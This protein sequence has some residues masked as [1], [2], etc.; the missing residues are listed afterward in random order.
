MG[1]PF[2][3]SLASTAGNLFILYL[4]NRPY[5]FAVMAFAGFNVFLFGPPNDV[6]S[7]P[8]TFNYTVTRTSRTTYPLLTIRYTHFATSHARGANKFFSQTLTTIAYHPLSFWHRDSGT[9]ANND[10]ENKNYREKMQK[11]HI[12][13]LSIGVPDLSV[14]FDISYVMIRFRLSIKN[15]VEFFSHGSPRVDNR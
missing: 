6:F 13:L 14:S 3:C 2:S 4:V 15:H 7:C 12:T 5:A 11:P 9:S 8:V 1:M 10:H